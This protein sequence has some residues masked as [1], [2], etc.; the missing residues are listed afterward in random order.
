MTEWWARLPRGHSARLGMEA[1]AEGRAEAARIQRDFAPRAAGGW[2]GQTGAWSG[3]R[4]VPSWGPLSA[5][6]EPP[7]APPGLAAGTIQPPGLRGW[8]APDWGSHPTRFPVTVTTGVGWQPSEELAVSGIAST[9][10]LSSISIPLNNASWA[11]GWSPLGWVAAYYTVQ[12]PDD[13]VYFASQSDDGLF[14]TIEIYSGSSLVGA[15]PAMI[16]NVTGNPY[17]VAHLVDSGDAV[18]VSEGSS[19][20]TITPSTLSFCRSPAGC[21]DRTGRFWVVFSAE[22]GS[23]AS[24]SQVYLC[25]SDTPGSWSGPVLVSDTVPASSQEALQ[26]PSVAVADGGSEPILLVTWRIGDPSEANSDVNISYRAA[27]VATILSYAGFPGAGI[28]SDTGEQ[29]LTA[30]GWLRRKDGIRARDPSVFCTYGGAF[31]IVYT[32]VFNDT[33]P[34][35]QTVVAA[36]TETPLDPA[37]WTT[38]T[39]PVSRPDDA[40]VDQ[41]FAFGFANGD[42]AQAVVVW[43]RLS[44]P[45]RIAL[46]RCVLAGASS[47]WTWESLGDATDTATDAPADDDAFPC[48]TLDD[49]GTVHVFYVRSTGTSAVR[50]LHRRGVLP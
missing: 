27:P 38:A 2:R 1:L 5:R 47:G 31:F 43:E 14:N 4:T 9:D 32:T 7:L 45:K 29:A 6:T 15:S 3:A 25:W 30:Y 17:G 50:F 37:S 35:P 11:G 23:G 12:G 26:F 34:P 24:A 49:D 19:T 48:C 36:W 22:G 41:D 44:T 16:A 20:S 13:L 18:A 42:L 28:D 40:L 39:L 8:G 10:D 21:M 46:A 33:P